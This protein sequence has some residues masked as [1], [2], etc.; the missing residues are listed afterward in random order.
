MHEYVI[1]WR[2]EG[3]ARVDAVDLDDAVALVDYDLAFWPG[4]SSWLECDVLNVEIN[5]TEEE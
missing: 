5:D 1:T 3:T 4:I 2:M